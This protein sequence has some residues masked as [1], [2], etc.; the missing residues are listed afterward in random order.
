M[1]TVVDVVGVA[2]VAAVFAAVVVAAAGGAPVS[3]PPNTSLAPQTQILNVKFGIFVLKMRPKR[4]V[5]K[6][7][8][9]SERN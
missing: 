5:Q 9:K 4:H 8:R 1:A 2:V 7:L 6:M 3:H